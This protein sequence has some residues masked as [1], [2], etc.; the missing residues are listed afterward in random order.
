MKKKNR[1]ATSAKPLEIKKVEGL[2]DMSEE[3]SIEVNGGQRVFGLFPTP[4]PGPGHHGH[5]RRPK[6]PIFGLIVHP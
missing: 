2:V 3:S 6:H 1:L 5:H 4:A